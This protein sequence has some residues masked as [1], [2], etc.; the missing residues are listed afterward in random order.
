MVLAR[1]N[2]S[3]VTPACRSHSDLYTDHDLLPYEGRMSYS[4][5][6]V[7]DLEVCPLRSH[8]EKGFS[9]QLHGAQLA[10]RLLLAS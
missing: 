4:S 9:V 7:V 8:F 6:V 1:P 10:D 2:P 3:R 5:E